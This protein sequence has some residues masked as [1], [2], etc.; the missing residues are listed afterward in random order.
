MC[1]APILYCS[2]SGV[3]SYEEFHKGMQIIRCD[4]RP[5][6]KASVGVKPYQL[7]SSPPFSAWV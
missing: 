4:T 3:L 2:S 6:S 1:V 5:W 7:E